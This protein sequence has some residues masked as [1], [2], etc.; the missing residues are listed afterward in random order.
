M[1]TIKNRDS[2]VPKNVDKLSTVHDL[3]KL[4]K[5]CPVCVCGL[6]IEAEDKNP[7]SDANKEKTL[8][9]K[10]KRHRKASVH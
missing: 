7:E 8:A 5:S 1:N 3:Q 6:V 10:V 4:L 2:H 9:M